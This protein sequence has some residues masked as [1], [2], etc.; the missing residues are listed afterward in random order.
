[1][2]NILTLSLAQT[3]PVKTG[4]VNDSLTLDV[5]SHSGTPPV[6]EFVLKGPEGTVRFLSFDFESDGTHDLLIDEIHGE[7]VFR[8]VPFRKPGLYH[9]TVYLY[10]GEGRFKREFNIAYTDFVWGRDNFQFA[11]DGK[12]E[13][14]SDFVSETLVEWAEDRFGPLS[15]EQQVLLL[16]VMYDIYKGSIGRF[17]G[18]TGEQIYYINNPERIPSQYGSIYWMGEKNRQLFRNMDYVQNDIVF[19]TVISGSVDLCGGQDSSR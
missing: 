4:D 1:M 15:Q 13:N 6:L 5:E 19:S 14:A 7:V 11:N 3:I 8:G 10:T 12:F 16:S 17:Y 2:F 18:F 9:T